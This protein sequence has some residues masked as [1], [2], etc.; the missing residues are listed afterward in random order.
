MALVT[1]C[2]E[3]GGQKLITIYIK[4]LYSRELLP[5]RHLY[6]YFFKSAV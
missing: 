5:K 6:A 3:G 2:W 1:N 4:N